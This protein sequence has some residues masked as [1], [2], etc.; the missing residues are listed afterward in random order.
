MLGLVTRATLVVALSFGAIVLLGPPSARAAGTTTTLS[1]EAPASVRV[2]APVVIRGTLVA[3]GTSTAVADAPVRLEQLVADAWT[4][5]DSALTGAGGRVELTRAAPDADPTYRL[6]F[7]GDPAHGPSVSDPVTVPTRVVAS[8]LALAG[9]RTVVDETSGVLHLSWRGADGDPV[10]GTVQILRQAVGTSA[11]SLETT[12]RTGSTGLAAAAVRPRTDTRY[13]ARGAAGSGW[14]AATSAALVVDNLPPARPVV[15][16]ARAPKPRILSP[17]PRAV[18]PGVDVTVTTIPDALW[19]RMSGI[20]W[21]R[22]CPVGRAGLRLVHA[23][24]WAFDGYRRRGDLVVAAS[25]VPKFERALA[26]LY[27]A[28]VPIRTM[29]LPDRFGYSARSGGA[30]DYA[31]MRADDTSAFNCRW[32]TGNHGVRSPHSSGRSFDI[33]TWENPYR[34]K[35]GWLPNGWWVSHANPRYAWRSRR[36]QVVRI[37]RAAGFR[38]TYGTQDAQHFDA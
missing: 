11:W 31:A 8:S 38:W 22:G 21:H 18:R 14:T 15:L 7:A 26:G 17:Q 13:Q 34:S 25:A 23:N 30:N 20:S 4:D 3:S 6:E 32:V 36:S 5:V 2:G 33:N 16:P 12:V 9:P 27:A 35:A 28:K 1:I 24:Y 37:M 19:Q 29:Y 10:A